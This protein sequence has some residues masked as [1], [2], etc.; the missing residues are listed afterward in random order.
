MDTPLNFLRNWLP[1]GS[2]GVREDGNEGRQALNDWL[3]SMVDAPPEEVV[4]AL[5]QRL[6]P[7]VSAQGNQHMR[8]RLLDAFDEISHGLLPTLEHDIETAQLPLS[9]QAKAKA[10]ATDN[11][12]KGLASGYINAIASIESRHMATG[13]V[14]LLQHAVQHAIIALRRRQ[15]LAYRAHATPSASSWQQLHDLY[16]TAQRLELLGAAK[17]GQS[18]EQLYFST[19]L[20]AYAD[21]G[22]FSRTELKL[23]LECAEIGAGLLR[24]RPPEALRDARP[25]TPLF[26]VAPN[27]DSPGKPLIRSRSIGVTGYLYLDATNLAATIR[28]DIGAKTRLDIPRAW[29]LPKASLTVL[30]TLAAMWGAQPTRR[31]SRMRFKPRADVVVGML[32]VSLFLAGGAFLRRRDDSGRRTPSGPAVSEWAMVDESPDGFGIR[33]LKGDIGSIEVGDIIGI[34]PRE[35]SQVQICLVR[36]VSNAGQTQ[37]E[38]GLQNLS[39]NALVVDL[40]GSNGV[41]RRKAILLPRLPAY[42]NAAG[43]IS[44]PDSVPDGLEILYP[45][46]DVKVRLKLAQRMESNTRNDFH[47]MLPG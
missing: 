43:L 30:R 27:D 40:P 24:I 15:L 44:A 31:F 46:G 37:L 22:K 32:D 29:L 18:L 16:R 4:T 45:T 36:R 19:L 6:G 34:R 21:P 11:L 17:D 23:L 3:E 42:N 12:L 9:P 13:L 8:I 1:L 14:P 2:L 38:I 25:E 47:L 35:S 41:A 39:P 26:V 33:Y 5:A 28:S 10:L 7:M 20:I